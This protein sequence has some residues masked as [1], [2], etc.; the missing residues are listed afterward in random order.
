MDCCP[1]EAC[2]TIWVPCCNETA[3]PATDVMALI[4]LAIE[5]ATDT[6]EEL[7]WVTVPSE[8]RMPIVWPERRLVR[9]ALTGNS[10]WLLVANCTDETREV[11]GEA[12]MTFTVVGIGI[13]I[14][15]GI[16]IA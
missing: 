15:M 8:L 11:E 14:V 4:L 7:I 9:S 1:G 13:G 10:C 3:C 6:C 12:E 2:V 5:E 16:E